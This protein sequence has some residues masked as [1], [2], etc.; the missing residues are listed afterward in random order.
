MSLGR[1]TVAAYTKM[2]E[3]ADA[4]AARAEMEKKNSGKAP[5]NTPSAPTSEHIGSYSREQIREHARGIRK[6]YNR[7]ISA[8]HIPPQQLELSPSRASKIEAGFEIDRA[9]SNW[10]NRRDSW[11]IN[12]ADEEQ[13]R[14]IDGLTKEL[15]LRYAE[16]FHLREMVT[17]YTTRNHTPPGNAYEGFYRERD[18]RINV[19]EIY[20]GHLTNDTQAQLEQLTKGNISAAAKMHGYL[21]ERAIMQSIY[22]GTKNAEA[23]LKPS[24]KDIKTAADCVALM[25]QYLTN[26]DARLHT[27]FAEKIASAREKH[28]T[29][30]LSDLMYDQ[31]LYQLERNRR[32]T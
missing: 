28:P 32:F 12:P 14:E 20:L 9:S 22:A 18:N 4:E 26:Q 15:M 29:E 6:T 27:A 13:T 25:K 30:K 23:T 10:T 3:E 8:Y 2:I 31:K 1:P 5:D 11:R 7:I 16:G 19:V 24:C 21:I 17:E